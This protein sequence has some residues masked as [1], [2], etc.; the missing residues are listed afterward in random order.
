MDGANNNEFEISILTESNRITRAYNAMI[1]EINCMISWWRINLNGIHTEPD[2]VNKCSRIIRQLENYRNEVC[3]KFTAFKRSLIHA[4][5]AYEHGPESDGFKDAE[6]RANKLQREITRMSEAA[7]HYF[8]AMVT[9]WF[10]EDDYFTIMD[11]EVKDGRYDFD[12]EIVDKGNNHYCV[13]VWQGQSK[14]H[15]VTREASSIVGVYHDTLHYD[16]GSVPDRFDDIASERGG[17]S[18]DS[19]HDLLKVQEKLGQLPDSRAGFLVACRNGSNYTAM[20]WGTDFPIVPTECMPPNKCIIVLIF[21]SNADFGKRG[22]AFTV[23]HPDFEPV[24]T[25]KNVIKS[26]GFTYDQ[27]VYTRKKQQFERFNL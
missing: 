19:K 2:V 14:H 1:K 13:E 7:G 18:M 25:A 11:I 24:E 17:V 23:H 16:P 6:K 20:L 27:D 21:G 26:L 5:Y 8:Q 4:K 3:S 15:H 10:H 22:T 12:I 9:K